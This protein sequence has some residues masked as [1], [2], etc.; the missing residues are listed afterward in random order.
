MFDISIQGL[1]LW[2]F[3]PFLTILQLYC[4][5]QFFLWEKTE[6]PE[7]NTDLPQATDKHY[8]I[9]LYQVHLTM[10]RIPSQL[11]TSGD[12]Q[13]FPKV[14]WSWMDIPSSKRVRITGL[15]IKFTGHSHTP[16]WMCSDAPPVIWS[17]NEY[18]FTGP[19]QLLLDIATCP[20]DLGKDCDSHWLH[21]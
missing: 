11:S 4:G 5:G 20:T 18:P 15:S 8:H 19:N 3:T 12:A 13:F 9:V 6:G 10:S 21:R 7:K 2:C 17:S 14:N 1:W 16:Q